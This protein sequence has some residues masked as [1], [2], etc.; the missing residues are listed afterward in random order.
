MLA[1]VRRIAQVTLLTAALVFGAMLMIGS[2][3]TPGW[4][5]PHHG[6]EVYVGALGVHFTVEAYGDGH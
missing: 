6:G 1:K 5:H 2:F 4:A 3:D